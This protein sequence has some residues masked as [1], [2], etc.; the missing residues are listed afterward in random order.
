MTQ[1][2]DAPWISAYLTVEDARRSMA[3]YVEVFGFEER[4]A[5]PGPSGDVDHGE[6]QYHDQVL[7]VAPTTAP[8]GAEK[9]PTMGGFQSPVT[10]FLYVDDV[11]GRIRRAQDHGAVVV[12]PPQTMFWG[13]R[14]GKIADLD[15]HLWLVASHVE[16]VSRDVIMAG[17]PS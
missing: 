5:R 2:A 7:M 14:I 13:D 8:G 10:L 11:D 6:L 1:T 9:S 3:W 17:P 4:M 12:M 15:G 16:D